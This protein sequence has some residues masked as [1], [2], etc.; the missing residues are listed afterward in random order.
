MGVCHDAINRPSVFSYVSDHS[1]GLRILV[2]PNRGAIIF[3][4]DFMH[5][6]RVLVRLSCERSLPCPIDGP[7]QCH[8]QH[9][10]IFSRQFL[11]SI[12][13]KQ[14]WVFAIFDHIDGFLFSHE[15]KRRAVDHPAHVVFVPSETPERI[16]QWGKSW[17]TVRMAPSQQIRYNG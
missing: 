1:F 12:F 17:V 14:F 10:F 15:F 5:F 6:Y 3:Y 11:R 8:V 7:D 9:G 16:N 13:R 2:F 4:H